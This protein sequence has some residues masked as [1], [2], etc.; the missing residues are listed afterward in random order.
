LIKG[1]ILRCV[2]GLWSCRDETPLPEALI[3][4]ACSEALQGWEK[5]LPVE[6]IV[7]RGGQ[8][9]PDVDTLNGRVPKKKWEAGLDGNPRPPWQHQY[10]AYLLDPRDAAVLTYL[11]STAGAKIAVREPRDKV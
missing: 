5:Q 1:G 8:S 10:V 4:L 11:N 2:D 9:L 3:V 6:T 7:K